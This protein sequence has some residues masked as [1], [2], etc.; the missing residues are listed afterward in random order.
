MRLSINVTMQRHI[1]NLNKNSLRSV[2]MPNS[3][4]MIPVNTLGP[5]SKTRNCSSCDI[6]TGIA[7]L[8]MLPVLDPPKISSSASHK[9][10]QK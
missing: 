5:K 1:S 7:P 6:S 4:G 9:K 3:V 10:Q 8:K 2:S